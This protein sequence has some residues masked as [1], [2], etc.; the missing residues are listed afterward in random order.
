MYV[1]GLISIVCLQG[2]SPCRHNPEQ[3]PKERS[4]VRD[5]QDQ[6]DGGVY[7]TPCESLKKQ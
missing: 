6:G 2:S 4:R 1:S 5:V 3:R 7:E